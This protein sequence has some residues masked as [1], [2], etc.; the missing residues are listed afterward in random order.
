ML[1]SQRKSFPNTLSSSSSS[2]KST[3]FSKYNNSNSSNNNTNNNNR[4]KY[5]KSTNTKPSLEIKLDAKLDSKLSRSNKSNN[6]QSKSTAKSSKN[7][8]SALNILTPSSPAKETIITN[9]SLISLCSPFTIPDSTSTTKYTLNN[10]RFTNENID[11]SIIYGN[12][13]NT[14]LDFSNIKSVDSQ[15][16]NK[17]KHL[18]LL[19][20]SLDLLNALDINDNKNNKSHL[21]DIIVSSSDIENSALELDDDSESDSES[22]SELINEAVIST[23]SNATNLLSNVSE[24]S[25]LN[26]FN[27]LNEENDDSKIHINIS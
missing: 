26:V 6:K 17:Q 22:E 19:A 5:A 1:Q 3:S 27:L 25:Y 4:H 9:D 12:L 15:K 13:N 23:N 11:L 18:T 24:K 21:N 14:N 20:Q 7:T 16:L 2:F 10:N 8:Q